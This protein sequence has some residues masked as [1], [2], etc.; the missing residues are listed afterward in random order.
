MRPV[1]GV[2]RRGSCSGP[3]SRDALGPQPADIV[4]LNDGD[5]LA[6][7]GYDEAISVTDEQRAYLRRHKRGPNLRREYI[8]AVMRGR[9]RDSTTTVARIMVGGLH[10]PPHGPTHAGQ[11]DDT[12][13]TTRRWQPEPAVPNTLPPL[14]PRQSPARSVGI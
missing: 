9:G 2:P 4:Y 8:V 7:L 5:D 6:D 11:R 14:P 10:P 12:S 3:E 1:Q 13:H